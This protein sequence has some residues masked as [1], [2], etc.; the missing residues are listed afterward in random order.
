MGICPNHGT[1]HS[2]YEVGGSKPIFVGIDDAALKLHL[3]A[4]LLDRVVETL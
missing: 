4:V 1:L 3:E 2:R